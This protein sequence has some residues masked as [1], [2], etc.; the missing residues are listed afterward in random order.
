[1]PRDTGPL[2]SQ[3]KN[4]VP[5]RKKRW[6]TYSLWSA[7]CVCFGILLVALTSS[8][9]IWSSS[10]QFCGRFCHSMTWASAAYKRGPHYVNQVGVSANC[11]ACHIPYDSRHATPSE[12][13]ELLGFKA[14]RGAKD[15]YNEA[16]RTIATK[17]EWERRRPALR[18]EFENYLTAHN[19][20]TCL[21]CHQL[22]S[23]GGPRSQMKQLVHD[24]V[25]KA[26]SVSTPVQ[27]A[28][29]NLWPPGSVK[30]LAESLVSLHH[31]VAYISPIMRQ[32]GFHRV[33][34]HGTRGLGQSPGSVQLATAG[35]IT[36]F[37][38]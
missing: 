31:A 26:G 32:L 8:A 14:Q 38:E 23:F 5:K 10:D 9:V 17:D 2:T 24:E 30:S 22:D 15:F 37:P 20:V 25:I 13:V 16:R 27:L 36:S 35:V 34:E 6:L 33:Q 7:A 18:S 19:Y 28:V 11:G 3:S 4:A 12:F 1:V 29:K 21:G